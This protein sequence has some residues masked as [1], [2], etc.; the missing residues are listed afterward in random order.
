MSAARLTAVW[1]SAELDSGILLLFKRFGDRVRVAYDP[2]QCTRP[3][4]EALFRQHCP[5]AV[6]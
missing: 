6:Q 3:Q 2:Q 1:E 4:A 5:D